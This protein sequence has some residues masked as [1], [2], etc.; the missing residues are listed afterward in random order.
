MTLVFEWYA[1]TYGV[2][3]GDLSYL[4]MSWMMPNFL[5]MMYHSGW[6]SK[7]DEGIILALRLRHAFFDSLLAQ[8]VP[9]S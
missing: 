1:V 4:R 3:G 9:S 6:G 2:F 8:A 5:W 7:E